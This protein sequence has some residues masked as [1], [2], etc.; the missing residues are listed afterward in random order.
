M[1]IVGDCSWAEL[2]SAAVRLRVEF[3]PEGWAFSVYDVRSRTYLLLPQPANT[4]E[5][6]QLL[7]EHRAIG[8]ALLGVRS[9]FEVESKHARV[10]TRSI[11]PEWIPFP[12]GFKVGT[13]HPPIALPSIGKST[14]QCTARGCWN[15]RFRT[16]KSGSNEVSPFLIDSSLFMTPLST[17]WPNRNRLLPSL[18]H[19]FPPFPLQILSVANLQPIRLLPASGVP[20]VLKFRH[21]ASSDSH[22]SW[23][24]SRPMRST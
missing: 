15:V 12:T 13:S 3:T 22:G 9:A 23:K 2:S 20:P 19:L 8:A 5:Q 16:A 21:N 1:E 11:S 14:G 18:E 10:G 17:H 4:E 24:R 7:A 6:G